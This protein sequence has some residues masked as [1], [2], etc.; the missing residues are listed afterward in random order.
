MKTQGHILLMA[1]FS[2]L[3]LNIFAQASDLFFS[4]YAEGSS[5]NKYVEI[6][7]GTGAAVDLSNYNTHRISNGGEWD[8]YIY[9]LTG[10]LEDGDVFI[11]ANS[12]AVPLI[13]AE[14]DMTSQ[15]TFYNGNDAVGLSKNDG[16]GGWLLIDAIGEDGPDPGSNWDVA[17]VSGATGEHTLVRKPAVC[18]PTTDWALSAGTNAD[19]SQW[20]VFGQDNFDNIGFHISDCAGGQTVALPTFSPAAGTYTSPINVVISCDTPG[21]DIYYTTDGSDPDEDSE[22][23]ESPIPVSESTTVKARAYAEDY[24]PSFVASAFYNFP[25]TVAT[26]AELR[27]GTIG[28]TY[29][30]TGEVWLT[31]QQDYRGNKYFQ[32]ETAAILIDDNSGVITSDFE[33]GD[34]VVG[35]SGVLGEYGGMM[36][37][38][39]DSDPGDP[40]SSGNFPEPQVITIG[41]LFSNFEAY[42]AELVQLS[43]ISFAD[44][45]AAF[46]NGSVYPISDASEAEGDFR[47]TFY[48]M[49]YIGTTIPDFPLDIVGLPNSRT[50]GEFIT[51]RNLDDFLLGNI[52]ATP[53]F[54]PAGGDYS[55]PVEVEILCATP[56]AEI[57][58]T[59]D[60]SDP[61]ESSMLFVDPI[62]IIE[63]TTLKARAYTEGF[64]PSLI[65]IDQ[66]NFEETVATLTELRAGV[67]GNTYTLSGEVWLTFQQTNRNQKFI[68]DATAGI[69]IDDAAG[70]I[71]SDFEIGDGISGLSGVLGEYNGMLQFVPN[72]DPGD[73]TSSG[74][75]PAP[76]VITLDELFTNFETYE[77]EL[78]KI[79][80]AEFADGGSTFATGETYAITDGSKATGN[81]R[82]SFYDVDYIGSEIPVVSTDIIGLPN[83]SFDG[84][85]ITARSS[86]DLIPEQVPQTIVVLSPNGGEV[87]EQG[88]SY[89]ITWASVNF[90]GNVN[91]NITRP[92]L[93]NASLTA[94]V[95]NTGSWTWTIPTDFPIFSTYKIR[96]AGVNAGDPLDLSDATFTIS[97]PLPDPNIVINEI[98]YNPS[99]DLGNDSDF[100]YLELYNNSGF[101][102]DLSGWSFA[103]GIEWVFE[104]GTQLADDDYIVVAL[105]PDSIIAHYG[106]SNVVGPF[107]GALGNSGETVELV[108]AALA[109]MDMVTYDD[110]GDW[111]SEPDGS[112]PSLELMDPDF[113]NSLPESWAASVV[114]DGTPGSENS[115]F[116]AELL[117]LLAPNG[118]ETFEQGSSQEITWEYSGFEGELIIKLIDF[119]L[120]DT[121]LLAT[122][123]PVEF[124][125]WDWEI[126]SDMTTGENYKIWIAEVSDGAPMDE[127]DASFS[128]VEIIVPII[129]LTQPNGGEAWAQGTAHEI[130]WTSEFVTSDVKIE[131]NDG[132]KALT[133]IEDSIPVT[134]ETYT[135]NIPA[136]L[137]PGDAYTIVIS[138]MLPG[139]PSDES[140]AP[141]S[142]IE[143]MP[144]PDLVINELM[145]NSP[146]NDNE[147]LELYNRED[148]AVDLAGFYFLDDDDTHL[149]IV[150]PTG[151]SIA[152]GQ[153]FTVSLQLLAPPL[154]FTPD[155]VGNADWSL[156]NGEDNLRLFDPSGQLVNNVAYEDGTPWPT[157]P[158]GDGP[159]LSLLD[160]MLDNSLPENWAASAQDLGTPGSE[161]FP[162][163]ATITVVA[164]NGG[165]T[166]Q[167]GT[168]YNISWTYANYD[169]T[170]MVELLTP[171]KATT[172]LGYAPVS[173][174]ELSWEVSQAVGENYRIKVSDSL[175]GA[176]SDES[177][178]DFAI[179][180][181]M[182]LP[183]VVINEIM[184]NPPE[185][186]TDSL[187]Y[188]ELY[189]N[190][191]Q[192]VNLLDW[193]FSAGIEYVFPDMDLT[194]GEYLVVAVNSDAMMNSFGITTY[195]WTDGGLSNSG[196]LI[197]LRNAGGDIIDFVSFDD[198]GLWPEAADG[199]GPSVSLSDVDADNSQA[200]NW[201]AETVYA[202]D[203]GE[204]ASVY[205]S[206]GAS[207][208]STP[209]QGILLANGWSGISSYVSLNNPS[210][211]NAMQHVITDL[212]VMQDFSK[213]FY[214]AY[215]INTIVNWEN[216]KGYQIKILT[217]QY[218]VL[219]GSMT[220]DKTASLTT[221][222]NSLPVLSDCA[223]EAAAL[224]GGISELIFVK[225]MGSD[226][227]YWPDGGLFSLDYLK[228]SYAYYI[229]VSAAVDITF[230]D[231]AGKASAQPTEKPWSNTTSW[232]TAVP[233][234]ASHALGINA[235]AMQQFSPGDVIGVFTQAGYCAGMV[236][237][238]DEN[239][240]L[241]AWANDQFTNAEDG[242][243][244]GENLS[245]KLYN[246]ASGEQS[247]LLPVFDQSLD[248]EGAFVNNGISRIVNFK[249]GQTGIS[250]LDETVGIYPNPTMGILN[251]NLDNADFDY[252][253]VF[254]TLGQKVYESPVNSG[255]LQINLKN[256]DQGIYIIKFVNS[257]NGLQEN[258]N[259][260]K[261]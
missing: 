146:G 121:T 107:S 188:I 210:V 230:A 34:G 41:E 81:F 239:T 127:S 251:I 208:F 17:G 224:F 229:K 172:V 156:G 13:L 130:T 231:C 162:T 12:S 76:Q 35:L 100:E 249:T 93:Y 200:E 180:P 185:S 122:N 92:P 177:D 78:V 155:F 27:A 72:A 56:D 132:V 159:S 250:T 83:S 95:A 178:G 257:M 86:A 182:E 73:A 223:V 147:W 256:L 120:E 38:V 252:L 7:N 22:S 109:S 133:L 70:T 131:L 134:N 90:T 88:E 30:V 99:G 153:Y 242:F 91:I 204:G 207:N 232:N 102:V 160:P 103:Q 197:E 101:A 136:E 125:I 116:G 237:V 40:V 79:M 5:N 124:G 118:G 60:G 247:D 150:F 69:L 33:I 206:P 89:Q 199:F 152:P 212:V 145:Y 58:Y 154:H 195:E 108:D 4:E 114:N 258:V 259:F 248:S 6:Y 111:P 175:T 85:A 157:E 225:E 222:W 10:I 201:A 46:A 236:E 9:P 3:T 196:E 117:T 214:P 254:S 14:A 16:L 110:G 24:N 198:G 173:A 123:V 66:Y 141:F 97:E 39:P 170:V 112:G 238:S 19:D 191:N 80:D 151:Y 115:V 216:D 184:Y 55:E 139:D 98:M 144:I 53:T 96:I 187:E 227:V 166:I 42:E 202:F 84:E 68:Q 63:T 218:M 164:P 49:D 211:E 220:T 74:N 176:P 209:G 32:D 57:Y 21:A 113:D 221:G 142:I 15:L 233:T 217:K 143:P 190:G 169:A 183:N 36:Q 241:M 246:A 189:N 137:A 255:Q 106:I 119:V 171:D 59:T 165:E 140:D 44:G 25:A 226:K 228:T 11:I 8:E 243:T 62:N 193:Y 219:Y 64:D 192:A 168:N 128:I 261:H 94:N 167:Q 240:L 181:A 37:F 186:G 82:T 253:E 45:G 194:A 71:T 67:I 31:F 149:P 235:A 135:W 28:N 161:N 148:V 75:F 105:K 234:A 47:T 205:A 51:S 29:V 158:D 23:Y 213:I 18:D 20:V 26:L 163:A 50:D 215:N 245:F 54:D 2:L 244:E 61:D 77:S 87:W 126:P 65:G 48:D 43:S 1:L 174:M 260:I 129:E 52:V 138:G 203:N 179:I 104:E